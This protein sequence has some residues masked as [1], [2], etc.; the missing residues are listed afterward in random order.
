LSPQQLFVQFVDGVGG[1]QAAA[2]LLGCGYAAV[3]HAYTGRREVSADMAINVERLSDGQFRAVDLR[4]AA[5]SELQRE[6][7]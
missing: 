1:R 2:T 6:A 4:A 3:D 7:G 5:N